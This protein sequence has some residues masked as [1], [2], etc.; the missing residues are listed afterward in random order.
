MRQF[1]L[2]TAL[3]ALTACGIV[4]E[5][6][7]EVSIS[8]AEMQEIADNIRCAIDAFE[9]LET[10]ALQV[11]RGDID[12]EGQDFTQPTAE[13]DFTATL[14]YNGDEFPGGTG[15]IELTFRVVADGN[16]VDPFEFDLNG[17]G[18]L[19]IEITMSFSGTNR[20]GQPMTFVADFDMDADLSAVDTETIT[21][22]GTFNIRQNGYT[23]DLTATDFA[24]TTDLATEL[25]T[26]ATGFIAG[27]IGIPDFAF[28]GD[29]VVEG[30][31]DKVR[32]KIEVLGQTVEDEEIALADF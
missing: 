19:Q 16:V 5:I 8:D 32:V 1:A 25:P 11:V 2:L 18:A 12:I 26:N 4:E 24:W 13:N 22:N 7:D 23:A 3:C 21:V 14:I 10:F 9:D 27:P 29:L 31:G 6:I 17:A 30:R 28:D 15:E 20:K